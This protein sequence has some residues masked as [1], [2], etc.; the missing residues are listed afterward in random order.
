MHRF[1]AS[2]S[3]CPAIHLP[4]LFAILSLPFD[5]AAGPAPPPVYDHVVVVILEN[6]S[7]A[8]IIGDTVDAPYLNSLANTG[9]NF[10]QSFAIEH[11]SQPNYLDIFSGSNQ[12]VTTDICLSSLIDADNLG[13]QLITA[14]FS[15]KGY[16]EDLPLAGS[17]TCSAALYVRKHNPWSDFA[18]LP[19]TSNL[20]FSSFAVDF[21]NDALPTVSFVIPDLCD[22]MQGTAACTAAIAQGDTWLETNLSAYID[23]APLHNSLLIVTW[24]ESD[25][26]NV[27]NQIPTIFYGALVIPGYYSQTINHYSV[28]ATIE[29]MYGLSALGGA[30]T[31]SIPASVFD[32]HIFEDGF[33]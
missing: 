3:F 21:G 25:S 7:Y 18:D 20:S 11:P 31:A 6:S 15:F 14:G 12:G 9:A 8:D 24:D 33:D 16:S 13:N 32:H 2:H 19:I 4:T 17:T 22:D 10:T 1:E 23:W 29:A 5:V 27:A 26:S 28:L 30:A